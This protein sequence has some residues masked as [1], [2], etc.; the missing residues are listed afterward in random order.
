MTIKE[1]V[2]HLKDTIYGNGKSGLK[3]D[4]EMLKG[5]VV[6]VKWWSRAIGAAII[7]YVLDQLLNLL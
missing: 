1:D 6:E 4:V 7:L 5:A 3:T 2:E